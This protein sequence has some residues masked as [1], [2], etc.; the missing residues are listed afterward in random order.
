MLLSTELWRQVRNGAFNRDTH[1]DGESVEELLDVFGNAL[2]IGPDSSRELELQV[3][4]AATG[5]LAA[6]RSVLDAMEKA[7]GFYDIDSIAVRDV[8]D[9]Y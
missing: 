5:S 9:G 1:L 2:L 4:L 8:T 6:A 3:A 7:E